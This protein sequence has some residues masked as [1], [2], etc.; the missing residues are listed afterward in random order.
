LADA[1]KALAQEVPYGSNDLKQAVDKAI[2]SFDNRGRQQVIVFLGSGKSLLNPIAS[3]ER[4]ALCDEMVKKEIA[5]FSVPLGL[6]LEP[7][8]L[9]GFATATGG[10]VV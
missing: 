6:N 4:L 7:A 9:H 8:N 10:L 3:N 2:K 5:F 1:F